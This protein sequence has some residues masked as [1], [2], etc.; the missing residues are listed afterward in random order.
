MTNVYKNIEIKTEY[1]SALTEIT[2]L[3][4]YTVALLMVAFTVISGVL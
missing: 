1:Y 3:S 4:G 2:A